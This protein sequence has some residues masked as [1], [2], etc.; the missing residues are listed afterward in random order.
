MRK[1]ERRYRI[2]TVVHVLFL[3][4][5]LLQFS[6]LSLYKKRRILVTSVVQ[7]NRLSSYLKTP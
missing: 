1:R 5:Q 6:H 4:F 3:F 2:D 7:M